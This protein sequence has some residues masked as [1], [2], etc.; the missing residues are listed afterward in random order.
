MPII[1]KK[2]RAQTAKSI[3]APGCVRSTLRPDKTNEQ[4]AEFASLV[5]SYKKMREDE[6]DR[7]TTAVMLGISPQVSQAVG[8]RELWAETPKVDP[9][10]HLL[11]QSRSRGVDRRARARVPSSPLSEEVFDP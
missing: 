11:Q 6:L 4:D 2:N 10:P 9:W 7:R 1:V 3:T 5:A 8:S